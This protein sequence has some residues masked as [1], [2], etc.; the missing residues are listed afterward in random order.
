MLEESPRRKQENTRAFLGPL[1]HLLS[2]LDSAEIL[3]MAKK[4][5][6]K[7]R[8]APGSRHEHLD[9]I[10]PILTRIAYALDLV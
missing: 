8:L 6:M 9:E 10:S 3:A 7:K 1:P 5:E 2:S 4:R